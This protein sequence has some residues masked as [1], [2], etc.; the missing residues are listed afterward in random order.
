MKRFLLA[1]AALLLASQASAQL[2]TGNL[3][4]DGRAGD[5]VVVKQPDVGFER[6]VDMTE[7]RYTF[8]RIPPGM[9]D[10]AV[11]HADGSVMKPLRV[12]VSIGTTARVPTT[13][14]ESQAGATPATDAAD[15]NDK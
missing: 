7:A 5:T 3:Q 13:V 12:Q 9:Y 1:I 2:A 14:T 8:R 10:V 11:T 4:I 15:D 6:K